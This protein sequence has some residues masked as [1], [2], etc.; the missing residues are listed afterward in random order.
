MTIVKL[1]DEIEELNNEKEEL[2]Q[3]L[4]HIYNVATVNKTID[5]LET[6]YD[7]LLNDGIGLI[8]DAKR[9]T[10]L[11]CIEKLREFKE[12]IEWLNIFMKY[13]MIILMVL[14]QI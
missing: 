1:L 13:G 12:N 7:E 5:I 3:E 4:Q 8:E 14:K 2:Q 11:R 10:V 6:L 9:L